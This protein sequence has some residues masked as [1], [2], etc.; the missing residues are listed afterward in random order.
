MLY[1]SL[2]SSDLLA[3][4]NFSKWFSAHW[5]TQTAPQETKL[6]CFPFSPEEV[7]VYQTG[8]FSL[9]ALNTWQAQDVIVHKQQ[10]SQI[11][12]RYLKRIG[13]AAGRWSNHSLWP[14]WQRRAT[15]G[16]NR[17]TVPRELSRDKPALLT[18]LGRD[19]NKESS[20]LRSHPSKPSRFVLPSEKLSSFPFT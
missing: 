19:V 15:R 18:H 10:P 16:L 12:G 1:I 13:M 11:K 8:D 9:K 17:A 20:P 2:L 5:T 3:P 4:T 6:P 7:W 14:W